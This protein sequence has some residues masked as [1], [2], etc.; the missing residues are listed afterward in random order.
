LVLFHNYFCPQ[1]W[2][3]PQEIGLGLVA[4]TSTSRV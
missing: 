3:Q 4:L 1:P 2:P